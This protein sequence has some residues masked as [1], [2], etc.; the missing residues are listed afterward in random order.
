MVQLPDLRRRHPDGRHLLSGDRDAAVAVYRIFRLQKGIL[1]VLVGNFSNIVCF[2]P[3]F[4]E[5][6]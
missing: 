2:I 5:N 3:P 1:L 6:F 4:P